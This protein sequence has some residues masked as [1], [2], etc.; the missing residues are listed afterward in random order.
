MEAVLNTVIG[1]VIGGIVAI[2]VVKIQT[3]GTTTVET[4]KREDARM[5]EAFDESVRWVKYAGEEM[6][7]QKEEIRELSSAE[8]RCAEKLWRLERRLEEVEAKA[9]EAHAV[10]NGDA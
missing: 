3:R 8:R 6:D 2:V 5:A 4:G 7:R 1:A 10:A 9:E